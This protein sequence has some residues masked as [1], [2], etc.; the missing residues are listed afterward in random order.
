MPFGYTSHPSS[1]QPSPRNR[2]DRPLPFVTMPPVS[3]F[4]SQYDQASRPH[5][6]SYYRSTVV[7]VQS[8]L[9]GGKD[10]SRDD[11]TAFVMECYDA[12][13][14]FENPLTLATGH[15][16]IAE[17][18]S[19]LHVVPGLMVS[20]MGD[21]AESH[22]YDGNRLVVMEHVLH[23]QFLPFLD[24]NHAYLVHS[25]SSATLQRSH[26]F[27]SLPTTPH[28]QSTPDSAGSIFSKT[29][30][31]GD[32]NVSP[33]G[34]IL[35]S[36][37]PRNLAVTLT[38]LHLR[39]HTRL[40]FNEHG[41]II[42]HEDT[43]GI[44]EMV[45]GIFPIVGHVYEL[46]RRGLGALAGVAARTLAGL[47]RAP[48]VSTSSSS[49]CHGLRSL[50]DEASTGRAGMITPESCPLDDE[51]AGD[52]SSFYAPGSPVPTGK[53]SISSGAPTTNL[54][55]L[56]HYSKRIATAT[57]YGLGLHH[58][59]PQ[60]DDGDGGDEY[61]PMG[62]KSLPSTRRWEP[63]SPQRPTTIDSD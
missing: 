52:F 22:G 55:A 15:S 11:I 21:I 26:S 37:S 7:E 29:R 62:S 18:F 40:L 10:R 31:A 50:D 3:S 42:R 27:F 38:T 6:P 58:P 23:V 35:S 44:K 9:Y 36:L 2:R 48:Q 56:H 39:L 51:G 46:Q 4:H 34:Q 57:A 17:M 54:A 43:W 45:E 28:P 33:I 53:S 30:S 19:L 16:A 49:G 47:S 41:K 12:N 1:S 8:T 20:E 14:V 24:P 63:V 32:G 13:A 59:R 61:E 60:G 25:P 5:S